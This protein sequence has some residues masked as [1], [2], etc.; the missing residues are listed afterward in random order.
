M[1][2]FNLSG[3]HAYRWWRMLTKF[4]HTERI[5]ISFLIGFAA[6]SIIIFFRSF[7]SNGSELFVGSHN[8]GDFSVHIPLIRSFS[9]GDMLHF[10]YPTFPGE[11]LR[12]HFLFYWSVAILEGVG[13]RIDLALNGLTLISLISVVTIIILVA[14][15]LAGGLVMAGI[16]AGIFFVF[17][18][19][20]SWWYYLF[21]TKVPFSLLS[22]VTSGSFASIGPYDGKLVSIFWNWNVLVN[23]R[24]LSFA[25]VLLAG[26]WY[27][28]I[29]SKYRWQIFFGLLCVFL[30]SW[31]HIALFAVCLL[32]LCC[33]VL[34][35]HHKR[36]VVMLFFVSIVLSIP[37]LLYF[38]QDSQLYP[39]LITSSIAWRPGFLADRYAWTW[40]VGS[41]TSIARWGVY[42][43][44][45]W[46]VL[47]L[48]ALIGFVVWGSFSQECFSRIAWYDAGIVESPALYCGKHIPTLRRHDQ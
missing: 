33:G 2:Q 22:L 36:R 30:L 26:A 40:E 21:D 38:Q 11:H 20:F 1:K 10:E 28:L 43:V 44:M 37:A 27:G 6:F 39:E 34:F 31:T 23:Q 45:N 3:S 19:S 4:I 17:N 14:R 25:G 12:Y 32:G 18:S 42:W 9:H 8:V 46:G 48:A 35:S 13:I 29:F 47:P 16:L 5:S 41:L 15:K 24:H 7:S